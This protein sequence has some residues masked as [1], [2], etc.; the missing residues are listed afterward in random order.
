MLTPRVSLTESHN[1]CS[2]ARAASLRS[3][4]VPSRNTSLDFLIISPLT[5]S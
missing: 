2:G 3:L 5:Y 4:S 1:V